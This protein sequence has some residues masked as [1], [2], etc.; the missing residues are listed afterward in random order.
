MLQNLERLTKGLYKWAIAPWIYGQNGDYDAQRYWGDRL[1]R[2]GLSLQGVGH[3]G[4][5]ELENQEEYTQ[6]GQLFIQACTQANINISQ[7][8]ILE[9]GCG[10]GFYTQILADLGARNYLGIDITDVLFTDLRDKFPQFSFQRQ[11]ITQYQ[12]IGR[13]D[14]IVMIDVIEHIVIEKK[15]KDTLWNLQNYLNPQGKIIIAPLVLQ[16]KRSLFHVNFWSVKTLQEI[17][18]TC[19]TTYALNFRNGQL[20]ILEKL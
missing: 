5:S 13:F 7:A 2:Y 6:A 4:R 3:E 8:R 20:M 12:E 14:L 10:T 19:K 18:E 15:I 16:E 1:T 11:D 9:V 17:M